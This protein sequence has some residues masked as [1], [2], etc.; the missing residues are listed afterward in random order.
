MAADLDL[1]RA[2]AVASWP[3]VR[4]VIY[5]L[6]GL[7]VFVVLLS[8]TGWAA[9]LLLGCVAAGWGLTY[10]TG[11]P[12]TLEERLSYGTV[13][14]SVVV[15]TTV[16]SL[17]MALGLSL[18]TVLLSLGLVLA[19]AVLGWRRARGL[20][21]TEINDALRRWRR[22]EA[23]P[24]WVLLALSWPFTLTV[25]AHGYLFNSQGLVTQGAGFYADWAAHLT[26]TGSF[27]F[28]HNFPPEFPVDP[29]HPMAYPF[30]IDLLAAAL[31]AMGTSLTSALVLT[32]GLLALAFPAVMYCAGLR[33]IRSR[34]GSA[35][36]VLVFGLSGG[37][38]FFL[39]FDDV[40]RSGLG[41]LRQSHQLY[42]QDSALNLQWLNPVLA[43]MLPQRSVLLGFSIALLVMAMLWTA[44]R[45]E[46][47]TGDWTPF[48]FAGVIT[49]LSPL[50]HLHGYG[51]V[52][53]LAAF[54]ALFSRRIQWVGFFVPAI[55]IGLPAVL[56][57]VGGGAA[58]VHPQVWWLA[59]K[60]EPV[61]FWLKNTSILVPA[62]AVA[63]LWRSALPEGVGLHLAPIWLWFLV[64]N[65]VV[66]QPWDWDNTKFFAY[67]AL[68]GALPVGAL[69]A[70]LLRRGPPERVAAYVMAALLM[71]SGA[72]DLGRALDS[73]SASA[74]FTGTGGLQVA[75][76]AREHTDPRAVF[77][78][79]PVHNEPIPTLAGRR[80]MVG[81]PGWLW[82]YG[83][84][85][86]ATRTHDAQVM[87]KG[88]P[89][90]LDLLHRYQVDYVVLGPEDA[91]IQGS[92][93]GYFDQIAERVYASGGYT[94]Y[95]VR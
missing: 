33:L 41:A 6:A 22:L 49:G 72:L 61:W 18:A 37:L 2:R 66:F 31:V 69:L 4:R 38:G 11:L 90:T 77:L 36:A 12:L 64:P 44:L 19:V 82:T 95:R 87:L 76:W 55:G 57:M 89:S 79:A 73:S 47:G 71:L 81:Y 58:S 92:N 28:G 40:R 80:V 65:F 21:P 8:L 7:G 35:L 30:M 29:G 23:W 14:G 88:D 93:A 56:W 68:F 9:V 5:A 34:V 67:W 39:L 63:F 25:L 1:T 32:S 26:Y 78:V 70:S 85:D 86:W 15:A 13:I 27:A 84:A 16:F 59:N 62:M 45:R 91:A 10:L 74:L 52:V 24:L 94:V 43:W 20:L 3:P 48:I 50:C 83:L 46:E 42:T 75:A 60:D 54:W 51:T 17:A 53:A